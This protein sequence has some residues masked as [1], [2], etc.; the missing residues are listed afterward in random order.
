LR[1]RFDRNSAGDFARS[2]PDHAHGD[3]CG[4]ATIGWE[5]K[6]AINISAV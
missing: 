6:R 5:T 1:A 2:N 4:Q 3:T